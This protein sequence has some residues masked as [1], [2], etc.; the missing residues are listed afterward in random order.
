MVDEAYMQRAIELAKK[1]EGWTNPNPMV[2][3]VVVKNGRVIGQGIH[4]K[5]GGLHAERNA[6]K[7]CS[8][9]PEGATL[10]VTLEPC[11]HYGKTPPCTT[12]IIESNL[13]RVVVGSKD[14]NVLVAGKGIEILENAG[15]QVAKG[16][17]EKECK[18]LNQVFFHYITKKTPFVA[19]KYAMTLDGKIAAY[20]GQSK[21][22]TG[23]TARA[24]VHQLR[25]KYSGIMVGI[26]TVL[27]DDPKLDCR[28]PGTK[29]PIRIICDTSLR[30]PL[31]SRIVASA[32]DIQTYVATAVNDEEKIEEL[33]KRGCKVVQVSKK[34]EH[35]DLKKLMV[36]LGQEGI[37]SILL[38]GGGTL[39]YEALHEGIVNYIYSYMAPKLL[40]GKDAKTAV[41]GQ[42]AESPDKAF[43]LKN[44]KITL[45]GDDILIEHE[46]IG[47]EK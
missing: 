19:M 7:N 33:T 41:E 20:T 31:N 44:R 4:E 3:A 27:Q 8:E 14:P 47:G 21:W 16:V 1:A 6:L 35:I 37:D 2:G 10:Y 23:E 42:G 36:L 45:L 29:N 24:H 38:E 18:E 43:L 39:N 17:L 32:G 22:I 25:H 40:G 26:G 12:A 15:I 9:S 11:C 46:M 28:L 13:S 5:F 34:G 30:I